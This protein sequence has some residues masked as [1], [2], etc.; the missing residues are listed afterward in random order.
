M[1]RFLRERFSVTPRGIWLAERVWEAHLTPDIASQGGE[2]LCLDDTQ[3]LQV[4]LREEDLRGYF[5]TEDSGSSVGI[6]PIQMQLR[7]EI[8]FAPPEKVIETLRA[9]ADERPGSMRLFGD[10]GEKFGSG[11]GLTSSAT[12]T[13]GSI[14]SSIASV[15]K[16]RGSGSF[17]PPSIARSIPPAERSTYRRDRTAR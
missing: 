4:G 14:G 6:Y 10:D 11:P 5:L 16:S 9:S 8:P 1:A 13:A 3:F 12:R 17:F 2:Y 15:T 7:Y